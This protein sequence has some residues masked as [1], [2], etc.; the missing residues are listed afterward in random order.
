MADAVVVGAGHNGLACAI[1][2]ARAGWEVTVLERADEPGGAVR[3][4][5]AT[6][7]GFRHDLCAAN[8][9]LFLGSRFFAELGDDLAAHGFSVCRSERPFCSVFPDGASVGVTT[10]DEETRGLLS[11]RSPGDARAWASMRDRF[12]SVAPH[13]FPLL[14][15]EL[16]SAAAARTLLLGMRALGRGWPAELAR[17]ALQSSREL[18]EER[19]ES[20]EVQAL[21]A[22]WGMHLDFPPDV[23]GGALFAFLESCASAENG[24]A[25]GRGGVRTLVDALVSLLESLGGRVVTSA[26]VERV[27]VERGRA[28]GVVVRGG[29]RHAARR[30]VVAN[31]TPTILYGRLLADADAPDRVRRRAAAYRYA[32]GT[33]MLHLA[34]A[35]LPRWAAG[36]HVREFSYVHIGPYMDDMSLAYQRAAAG[37]LPE[38]PMLVVG[39]PTAVDPTRAP[40]GRHVLWVQTRFVPGTIR[41]DAAGEIA[42]TGWD[43]AKEAY[44]DRV[45]DTLEGYAPGLRSHVL[46][47]HVLSPLDLERGNPNLVGGDQCSGSHHPMQNFFLRPFPGWSRYRTPV[48]GL[49]ACGASTWPGAGVGAGSGYLLGK[50]LLSSRRRAPRRQAEVRPA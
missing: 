7:P 32:P 3:T 17:L 14:G 8:L 45:L 38:R 28:A 13:L 33:L 46:G 27:L 19:F 29:E 24:M 22:A 10:D 4:A 49:Y 6:L 42:A 2:L 18:V 50:R 5:E 12:R 48:E 26:E 47:R 39:Q 15:S 31:V 21:C 34:L 11:A 35:E 16:P 41:G 20:A 1:L 44:A 30:A 23:P 37:L 43:E 40:E 9:N 25:L 36:E